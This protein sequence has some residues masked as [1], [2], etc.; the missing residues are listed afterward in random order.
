MISKKME[1]ALNSQVNK[2]L[3]SAYLY[4]AMS[5]EAVH[6]GFKGVGSWFMVQAK[7]EMTHAMKFYGYLQ[8]QQARVAL[9]AIARPP[10]A[11]K[12]VLHMFEQTLAHEKTVTQSIGALMDLAQK[13]GD[14][15]TAIALQWFVS[16]Q[17]EEEA[18]AAEILA[19][20]Q[21]IGSSVGSLFV[22]DH[23][24][25]KREFGAK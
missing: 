22:I 16:E 3:Y 5:A 13:E 23:R 1:A 8:D 11:F 24:L 21:M 14:H 25:G 10:A 18:T 6:S 15:A 4:A 20:L 2:E 7:E 19:Q 17:V 9:E 12:S